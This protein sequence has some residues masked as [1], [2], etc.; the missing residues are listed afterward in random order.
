MYYKS[1]LLT[2][3]EAEGYRIRTI[4]RMVRRPGLYFA[5]LRSPGL[6]DIVVRVEYKACVHPKGKM[7]TLVTIKEDNNKVCPVC[8]DVQ[9]ILGN[10][11]SR[12]VDD[13]GDVTYEEME[14]WEEKHHAAIA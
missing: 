6:P 12:V 2:K 11:V 10:K 4:T 13:A 8:F 9:N 5:T 7:Y 14:N 1:S 3:E